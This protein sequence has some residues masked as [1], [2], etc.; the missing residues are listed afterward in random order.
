MAAIPR[1]RPAPP[2]V[3]PPAPVPPAIAR[4]GAKKAAVVTLAIAAAAALVALFFPRLRMPVAAL[5]GAGVLMA[6][7]HF[8]FSMPGVPTV[9]FGRMARA[10]M[11]AGRRKAG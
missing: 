11:G 9:P 1:G 3:P 8:I 6:V 10:V 7:R 5:A 4:R 2:P